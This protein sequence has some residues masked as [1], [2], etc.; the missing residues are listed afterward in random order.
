MRMYF[1]LKRF[2]GASITAVIFFTAV[3]Q[4][5]K[6]QGLINEVLPETKLIP[7]NIDSLLAH[8]KKNPFKQRSGVAINYAL[9]FDSLPQISMENNQF[10]IRKIISIPTAKALG[11]YFSEFSI[12]KG[13]TLKVYNCRGNLAMPAFHHTHNADGGFFA[14]PYVVGDKIIIEYT[15]EVMPVITL[16]QVAFFYNHISHFN[17][18]RDFGDS[19]FCQ[20]NVN[21]EEGDKWKNQR[22]ATVRISV[23]DQS[24]FYWC[25]GVL[26][27]NTFGNCRPYIL[28]ADHCTEFSTSSDYDE[29]VFYFNYQSADCNNPVDELAVNYRSISG[30][31]LVARTTT[32]GRLDSDLLLMELND[33]IPADFNAYYSGWDATPAVPSGGGVGIHHPKGDIKK[34]STYTNNPILGQWGTKN[35][36]H[37]IVRWASTQNGHG[38]TEA[39][40]SGSGLFNAEGLLV[41]T[42]T[43]GNTVCNNPSFTIDYYGR[44]FFHWDRN[45]VQADERIDIYLDPAAPDSGATRRLLGTYRPCKAL[46]ANVVLPFKNKEL[47]E[48]YP[49]PSAQNINFKGL[50]NGT[51][52][53]VYNQI[54][55]CVQQIS[56]T[57][58]QQVLLNLAPGMY[59]AE[60]FSKDEY[61]T[62][63]FII[64]P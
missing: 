48:V 61:Q 39:G 47:F 31:Q 34:V 6:N 9:S 57:T 5:I 45:G 8:D 53:H 26:V 30:C 21:C 27:N 3:G 62:I 16:H 23:K 41:G 35:N 28:S 50:K 11:L 58:N 1:I 55:Q 52:V 33:T 14:T 17:A 63:K 10:L 37:L 49:N 4:N 44:M 19:D 38:V 25:T 12:P 59:F 60:A 22:D 32:G 13:G 56:L 43:G 15:G 40:S 29:F 54:G 36:T 51:Y 2:I 24:D 64:T 20:V 7:P 46:P 42:L 18:S